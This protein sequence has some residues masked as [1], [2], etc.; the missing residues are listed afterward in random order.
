YGQDSVLSIG[1]H[2]KS[3]W[4]R[5]TFKWDRINDRAATKHPNFKI[6]FIW[7]EINP[8]MTMAAIKNNCSWAKKHSAVKHFFNKQ[9][10]LARWALSVGT[11]WGGWSNRRFFLRPVEIAQTE[12]D[13]NSK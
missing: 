1:F 5:I 13:N 4:V 10:P 8:V 11:Y 12:N 3:R 2:L 9:R 7:R 6:V